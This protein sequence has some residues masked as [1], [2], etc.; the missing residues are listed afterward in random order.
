MRTTNHKTPLV[1]DSQALAAWETPSAQCKWAACPINLADIPHRGGRYLHEGESKM[2]WNRYFGTCNP[3][4]EVWDALKRFE[5]NKC[6]SKD[7]VLLYAFT[8]YHV[9]MGFDEYGN[10][11]PI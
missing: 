8:Y 1:S 10:E 5:A 11:V 2:S 9:R 6:G 7:L 3:P 4:P